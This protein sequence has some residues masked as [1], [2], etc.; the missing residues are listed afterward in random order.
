MFGNVDIK[1]LLASNPPRIII[2]Q[3]E[4][5]ADALSQ[6][7]TTTSS[8]ADK[9]VKKTKTHLNN[10]ERTGSESDIRDYLKRK[11]DAEKD[12]DTSGTELEFNYQPS[13]KVDS[14]KNN[15]ETNKISTAQITHIEPSTAPS[16][17]VT[18]QNITF[19]MDDDMLKIL[20]SLTAQI[21]MMRT[22]ATT[23]VNKL[24]T[25]IL[26]SQKNNAEAIL[27]IK[28]DIK[29]VVSSWN[30]KWL[31]VQKKQSEL[32]NE[33]TNLKEQLKNKTTEAGNSADKKS[34]DL[35]FLADKKLKKVEQLIYDQEKEAKKMNIIIKNHDWEPTQVQE[36]TTKFLEEKFN[37]RA[38]IVNIQPV[39]KAGKLIR[40]KLSTQKAKEKIMTDKA[41]VL[42]GNKISIVRDLTSRELEQRSNLIKI[43]KEKTEQG[44]KAEIRGNKI[45]VG[46]TWHY[47]DSNLNTLK[48]AQP[49][50]QR[51]VP[52][53]QSP[54]KRNPKN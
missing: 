2:N 4:R 22:E 33:I 41:M 27:E 13:K 15:N 1:Q 31:D 17:I 53:N 5:G 11:R 49:L 52:N 3:T 44:Q 39:D 24:Q 8:V 32:E 46:D 10:R 48:T 21:S 16:P 29:K 47:W 51:V 26:D 34:N 54:S 19:N 38:E 20:Q 6:Q 25:Q 28:N 42:K 14:S 9:T 35:L 7:P 18:D 45:K 12:L 50:K 23:N 36:K 37:T 43:M 40:V 30:S